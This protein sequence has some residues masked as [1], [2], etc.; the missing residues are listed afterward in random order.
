MDEILTPEQIDK[1]KRFI[2]KN[3]RL[4][5]R[6]LF[7]YFFENGSNQAC[8]KAL[9]AYQN[10]DGGFGN[11]IEPDLLC[12]DSTAIGAET[13]MYVL[14]LLNCYKTDIVDKLVDWIATH[15]N[16]DGFIPHPPENLDRYPYQPWWKNPDKER[17]LSLAGLLKKWGI[18]QPAFFERVRSFYLSVKLPEEVSFYDYPFF[19]YLKYCSESAEDKIKLSS[20]IERLPALISKYRDHFPLFSRA[21]FCANDY[22]NEEVL[23]RE[24]SFF[25]NAMQEDGGIITPYPDFPWWRPLFLLDGLVLLK[26]MD[27]L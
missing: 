23:A 24:A 27:F 2:Y 17:I 15:Q 21:W 13:A 10:E 18:D 26:K 9:S 12:P 14:D 20:M 19:V 25:M 7:E 6:K 8:L 11:G 5:E 16:A 3:G 22:V 1:A 4:L